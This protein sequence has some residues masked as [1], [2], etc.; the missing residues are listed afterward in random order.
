[1]LIKVV[2]SWEVRTWV[3]LTIWGNPIF[4][5]QTTNEYISVSLSQWFVKRTWITSYMYLVMVTSG[6][7]GPLLLT[8]WVCDPRVSSNPGYREEVSEHNAWG[9]SAIDGIA[10]A[11]LFFTVDASAINWGSTNRSLLH[12]HLEMAEFRHR[13]HSI[14]YQRMTFDWRW[15]PYNAKANGH[16][17]N[18]NDYGN[19][20]ARTIIVCRTQQRVPHYQANA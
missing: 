8:G 16:G 4:T 19:E 1:M 18:E 12:L 15:S 14:S 9:K 17:N 13:V 6:L 11:W 10:V 7:R 3:Y 2:V 5:K 20:C